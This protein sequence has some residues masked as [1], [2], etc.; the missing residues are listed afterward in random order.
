[1][2][3]WET[4]F[5]QCEDLTQS[6]SNEDSVV[7]QERELHQPMTWQGEP[8][9]SPTDQCVSAGCLTW[10]K[11]KSVE[12]EQSFQQMALDQ[13]DINAK[14]QQQKH[15]NLIYAAYLMHKST[16]NE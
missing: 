15:E 5:P 12:E 9:S 4:Q 6:Y 2:I 1:M 8:G 14:Q 13:S 16:E 7:L 3:E 11:S 10:C